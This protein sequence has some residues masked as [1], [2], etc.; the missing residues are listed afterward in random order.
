[1]SRIY[2]LQSGF[3]TTVGSQLVRTAD[4]DVSFRDSL[5]VLDYRVTDTSNYYDEEVERLFQQY[6]KNE[7]VAH[8]FD[9]RE[10]VYRCFYRLFTSTT[11]S[12]WINL[13]LESRTVGNLHRRF[14]RDVLQNVL[15]GGRR[16]LANLQYYQL[17]LASET[18][19]N[20]PHRPDDS[21]EILQEF[22][23]AN[24]SSEIPFL[25]ATWTEEISGFVDMLDVLYVIFG[26]RHGPQSVSSGA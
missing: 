3:V 8:N 4:K 2:V 9:Y 6:R 19:R 21:D 18:S 13:Q 7:N 5:F 11:L 25:L 12:P 17:L 1:M 16:Q 22:T 23:K 15:N 26:P 24:H 14:L 20:I 10:S